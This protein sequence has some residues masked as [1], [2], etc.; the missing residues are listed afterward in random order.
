ME[1]T[2]EDILVLFAVNVFYGFLIYFT[3]VFLSWID[4]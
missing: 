4:D 2:L 1:F 3:V